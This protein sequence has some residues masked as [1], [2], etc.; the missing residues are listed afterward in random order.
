M[1]FSKD[2]LNINPE[3]LAG[4]IEDFI[5]DSVKNHFKRKGIIIGLSG[6][7]DSSVCAAL[8]V[9]ALGA[10]RVVGILLPEKDSNPVSR[11]YGRMVAES[12]GIEC[13]E[14]E[15][16]SMLETFEVYEKRDAIVQSAIERGSIR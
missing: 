16:T 9:R 14:V 4:K 12:L 11:E 13:H 7:L 10:D 8:S 15:L 3:E 1:A 2:V 6:G 5:R